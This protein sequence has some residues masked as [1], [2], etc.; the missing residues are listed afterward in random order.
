M[1]FHT[2][3]SAIRTAAAAKHPVPIQQLVGFDRV[4]LGVGAGTTVAFLLAK[5]R[6]ALTDEKGAAVLYPGV[7][8]LTFSRGHGSSVALSVTISQEESFV[9]PR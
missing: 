5:A 3:S 1:V 2:I 9:R 4:R 6:L 7:Q 8:T